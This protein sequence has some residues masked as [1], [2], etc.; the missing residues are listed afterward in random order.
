[1]GKSWAKKVKGEKGEKRRKKAK[2]SEKSRKKAK[3]GKSEKGEKKRKKAKKSEKS[4][5]KSKKGRKF[6]AKPQ[7]QG[8]L[9]LF[10]G[11]T[12]PGMYEQIKMIYQLKLKNTL[13]I[14]KTI[15]LLES[16]TVPIQCISG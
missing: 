15:K 16:R 6:R 5:K 4:R 12:P 11:W 9:R 2:K 13:P 10:W 3:G 7:N 8:V 14:Q 1:M